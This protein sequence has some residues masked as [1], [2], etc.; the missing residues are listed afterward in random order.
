MMLGLELHSSH[1]KKPE[2]VLFSIVSACKKLMINEGNIEILL[3][4]FFAFVVSD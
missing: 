2:E 4:S 1:Q 3:I